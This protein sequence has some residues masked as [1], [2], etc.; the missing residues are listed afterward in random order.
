[1]ICNNCGVEGHVFKKCLES[2]TSYGIILLRGMYNH[3]TLPVDPNTV[4]LIMI[5]RKD[6]MS[7]VEFISGKYCPDDDEYIKILLSN[8]TI[9]ERLNICYLDFNVLWNKMWINKT[10]NT[11]EYE[12]ALQK[13][14]SIDIKRLV[15][16]SSTMFSETEWG[17]PK[18]RRMK[19]ETNLECAMREFYE[20]TNIPS[21]S[22]TIVEDITFTEEFIGTNKVSYK[23]IYYIALLH[24]PTLIN[25]NN[26]L[27]HTQRCEID[28]IDWKSLNVAKN[29]T[30]PHYT[31]RK[32]LI[33]ELEQYISQNHI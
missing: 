25:L 3:L 17:F 7:Y 14:N 21:E 30:R 23:H 22:Y 32:R 12:N 4:S 10:I 9:Q 18:G 31:E 20:E 13:F 28:K 16:E 6:S 33:A 24:D 5:R 19:N 15:D 11:Y 27:T 1:M 8:M 26:T 29:L 2:K